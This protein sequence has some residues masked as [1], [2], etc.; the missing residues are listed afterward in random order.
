M[1]NRSNFLVKNTIKKQGLFFQATLKLLKERHEDLTE[2]FI[3]L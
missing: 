2:V 1:L 3:C